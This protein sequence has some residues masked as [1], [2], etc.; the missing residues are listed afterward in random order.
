M[1][2][3]DMLNCCGLREICELSSCT[4]LEA[5][6]N[7]VR[8][9]FEYYHVDNDEATLKFRHVIFTEAGRGRYGARFAAF[10]RNNNLG[11]II[12]TPRERNPNSGN[13][14]KCFVWTLNIPNIKQWAVDHGHIHTQIEPE[15]NDEDYDN[16][17]Q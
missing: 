10:I 7:F 6:N 16:D 11:T 9:E 3:N 5:M 1:Y 14:L 4:A 13:L 2:V 12:E 8:D 17:C 15:D